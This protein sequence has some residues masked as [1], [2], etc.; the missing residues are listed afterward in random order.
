M[1]LE[2]I[3]FSATVGLP[4][5]AL[6]AYH[7]LVLKKQYQF[8]KTD[9]LVPLSAGVL[10]LLAANIPYLFLER[11]PANFLHHAIGGGVVV[12]IIALYFQSRVWP[13]QTWTIQ[14]CFVLAVVNILGNANE[15]LE[16]AAELATGTIYIANKFDTNIDLVANNLGAAVG[17]GII[18]LLRQLKKAK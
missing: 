2:I 8:K 14:A 1:P 10:Q 5:G 9:L 3:L 13:H 11:L 7:R 4:L 18:M 16:L 15:I 17:F 6:Y 12:A